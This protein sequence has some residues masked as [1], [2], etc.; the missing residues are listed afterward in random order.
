MTDVKEPEYL[1]D[2]TRSP[3]GESSRD[4]QARAAYQHRAHVAAEAQRVA[5]EAALHLAAAKK[6]NPSSVADAEAAYKKAAEEAAVRKAAVAPKPEPMHKKTAA[7]PAPAAPAH[8]DSK[9]TL[10]GGHLDDMAAAD[11]AAADKAAAAAK[12]K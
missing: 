9:S 2:P 6:S 4:T 3:Y 10:S 5:D 11:K 1:F 7:T 8:A 12:K